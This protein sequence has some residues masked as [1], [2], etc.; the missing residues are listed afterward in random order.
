MIQKE[1][2]PCKDCERLKTLETFKNEEN[3]MHVKTK[4]LYRQDKKNFI[5]F[6]V[7]SPNH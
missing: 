2:F 4:I 1:T 6:I 5:N 3:I 7:L